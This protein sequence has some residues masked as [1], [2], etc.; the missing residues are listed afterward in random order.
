MRQHCM[1]LPENGLPFLSLRHG[2]SVR[3]SV[4]D[5]HRRSKNQI[6]YK[7]CKCTWVEQRC[8][9]SEKLPNNYYLLQYYSVI[10]I[11]LIVSYLWC[12]IIM[13][14]FHYKFHIGAQ[15]FHFSVFPCLCMYARFELLWYA[16]ICT[17][18]TDNRIVFL[19]CDI[20]TLSRIVFP[21]PLNVIGYLVNLTELNLRLVMIMFLYQCI[22]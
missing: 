16:N 14:Q 10:N 18:G 2:L 22:E 13:I 21:S 5:K 4:S 7:A 6:N 17:I 19:Q 12:L 11:I 9:L 3:I 1:I 20:F 15:I 8:A